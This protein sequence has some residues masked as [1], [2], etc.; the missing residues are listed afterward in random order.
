[1]TSAFYPLP[2][3]INAITNSSNALVTFTANHGYRNG[4]LLRFHVPIENGMFELDGRSGRV[5]SS[6][7]DTVTVDVETTFFTPFIFPAPPDSTSYPPEAVPYGS[8]I[9][10]NQYFR[11]TN[12]EC[13][14]DNR[15]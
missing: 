5:L 11:S 3:L 7:A 13:S 8:G 4:Q 6:T 12:L 15:P 10:D 9:D 14:F 1:M 2:R